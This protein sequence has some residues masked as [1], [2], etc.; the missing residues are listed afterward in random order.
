MQHLFFHF[1][2]YIQFKLGMPDGISSIL[3][4]LAERERD[5]VTLKRVRNGPVWFI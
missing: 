2:C 1:I 5:S 3:D 4:I